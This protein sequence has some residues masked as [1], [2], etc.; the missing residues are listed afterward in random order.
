MNF[1]IKKSFFFY[2]LLIVCFYAPAGFANPKAFDT[3]SKAFNALAEKYELKRCG[4]EEGEESVCNDKS[5]ENVDYYYSGLHEHCQSAK[6][7]AKTCC[8]DPNACAN[9]GAAIAKGA[10]VLSPTILTT[11]N[12]YK[13]SKEVSNSE[14]LTLQEKADKLCAADNK[15]LMGKFGSD[16]I[17]QL[18]PLFEKSCG[19]RIKTCK[20]KCDPAVKGFQQDFKAAYNHVITGGYNIKS[21]VQL[22]KT[23]LYG[24]D[25]EEFESIVFDTLDNPQQ[26]DQKKSFKVKGNYFIANNISNENCSWDLRTNSIVENSNDKSSIKFFSQV[27]FYAKAYHNTM[28]KKKQSFAFN[29]KEIIDC[30][31]I[32]NR[33]VTSSKNPLGPITPPMRKACKQ[34]VQQV[35]G[36]PIAPLPGSAGNVRNSS[37]GMGS[38]HGNNPNTG[39]HPLLFSSQDTDDDLGLIDGLLDSNFGDKPKPSPSEKPPGFTSSK[40]SGSM[41]GGSPGGGGGSPGGG[42]GSPGAEGGYPYEDDTSIGSFGGGFPGGSYAD[43]SY[44]MDSAGDGAYLGN[45]ETASN[46][47]NEGY[48]ES[49]FDGDNDFIETEGD[50]SIFDMASQKIQFFCS[51]L[52]CSL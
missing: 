26:I 46:K 21:S 29:E 7:K 39:A 31:N 50:G 47:D 30:G 51:N 32:P 35:G 8:E 44:P 17:G 41:A 45:R 28:K 9:I 40:G 2:T 34:I 6:K 15:A 13:V 25:S 49:S 23:C 12:Q 38:L 3:A 4:T 52:K 20:Q 11:I 19:N 36:N 33:V 10:L 5:I 16:L 14:G 1:I 24:E 37:F 48:E 42:G 18:M 43:S 22:A 27:L